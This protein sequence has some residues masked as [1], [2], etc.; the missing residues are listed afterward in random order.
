MVVW[1]EAIRQAQDMLQAWLSK[2]DAGTRNS[3]HDMLSVALNVLSCAGFG[4]SH[5]FGDHHSK[6]PAGHTMHYRDALSM[7]LKNLVLLVVFPHRMFTLPFLPFRYTK[8]GQAIAEFRKYMVEIVEQERKR[9]EKR[10]PGLGNLAS[11][12]IHASEEA[13][14]DSNSQIG[15]GLTDNEIYGNIFI[16]NLAGHETTA[17][18]LIYSVYLLSV[19]PDVQN[20]MGEELERV[21]GGQPQVDVHDYPTIFPQLQRLRAVMV[22]DA[23]T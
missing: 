23:Q 13:K 18:A 4:I 9:I 12:L 20:W 5:P 8:L 2:G 1:Q 21:L 7:V 11:A 14:T 19:H 22:C 17:Y 16:Y 15:G 6:L 3:T 10:D